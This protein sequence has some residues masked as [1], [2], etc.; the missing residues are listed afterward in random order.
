MEI[1]QEKYIFYSLGNFVFDQM[2]SHETRQG[3]SIIFT[4]TKEGVKDLD[5]Y[6]VLIEDYCQPNLATD[7][8]R[9]AIMSRL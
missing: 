7:K 8:E 9:E 2:W 5:Y 4:F 1:Y 3:M 6:P